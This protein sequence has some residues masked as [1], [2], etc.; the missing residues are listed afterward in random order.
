MKQSKTIFVPSTFEPNYVEETVSVPT[1]RT[2]KV[3]FGMLTKDEVRKER[4]VRRDG[5]S[6][7][8]IDGEKLAADVSK[9]ISEASKEG[10][11]VQ[12]IVPITS[13]NWTY[14][15]GVISGGGNDTNVRGDLG[16]SMGWS[17]TSGMMI[18]FVKE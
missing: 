12:T 3:F 11:A 18:T 9:S 4:Q 15:K 14:E 10:Y 6:N 13:G 7:C 2:T 17:F 16:Y 5:Y 8:S 1:G